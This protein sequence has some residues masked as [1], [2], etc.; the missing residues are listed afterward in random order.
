MPPKLPTARP[1]RQSNRSSNDT[2]ERPD[3]AEQ[4]DRVDPADTLDSVDQPVDRAAPVD[5]PVSRGAD[6]AV[7]TGKPDASIPDLDPPQRTIPGDPAQ[8]DPTDGVTSQLDTDPRTTGDA[9]GGLFGGRL[10]PP[11]DGPSAD[12]SWVL[13]DPMDSFDQTRGLPDLDNDPFNADVGAPALPGPDELA[14]NRGSPHTTIESDDGETWLEIWDAN[15]IRLNF[16]IDETSEG[17]DSVEFTRNSDGDWVNPNGDVFSQEDLEV[18]A[19]LPLPIDTDVAPQTSGSD[20]VQT[21]ME[22]LEMRVDQFVD[23]VTGEDDTTTPAPTEDY[24][25]DAP[26]RGPADIDLN[27]PEYRTDVGRRDGD[28]DWGEGAGFEEESTTTE[29]DGIDHGDEYREPDLDV[30]VVDQILTADPFTQPDVDPIEHSDTSFVS[31]E[32]D[33]IDGG[34]DGESLDDMDIA[35]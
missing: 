20:D 35:E 22:R 30:H 29:Y 31:T 16:P 8:H 11:T 14:G 10:T 2:I 23:F 3:R 24:A 18:V 12:T 15:T 4:P 21:E 13:D 1:S 26:G 28:I 7:E 5:A 33:E 9:G 32:T 6:L 25:P 17:D 34:A 19:D 27:D